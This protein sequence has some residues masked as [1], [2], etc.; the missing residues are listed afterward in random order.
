M[1]DLLVIIRLIKTEFSVNVFKRLH[2][3][4]NS[5]EKT[6]YSLRCAALCDEP[7]F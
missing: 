2:S 7:I 4:F 1:F 6:T 3:N 5:L